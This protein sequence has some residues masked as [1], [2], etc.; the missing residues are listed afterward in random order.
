MRSHALERGFRRGRDLSPERRD[1]LEG[2]GLA[3]TANDETSR[4]S[5]TGRRRTAVLSRWIASLQLAAAKKHGF[6]PGSPELQNA[7]E[8]AVLETVS[9]FENMVHGFD[10]SAA[11]IAYYRG[12][13]LNDEEKKRAALRWLRGE[14]DTKTQ[15]REYLPV[16]SIIDDEN[17][18]DY[19]KLIGALVTAAG[20]K[21]LIVFIDEAVNL[22]KIIQ[23]ASRESNYEKLLTIFND[24]TQGK[25]SHIAFFFGG[26]P[27]FL[28]DT[29]RGLFSYEALRSRLSDNRFSAA[30]RLDYS[31]PVLRR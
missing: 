18:Y 2:Q 4:Q 22:Y 11:V 29:R 20:L 19:L 30:G 17:W 23:S 3:T 25:L 28:E 14:F 12:V 15:A 26:T 10:F 9:G 24:A 27:Q 5:S 16:S 8:T 13:A 31:A 7:V 21:G 1:R 6:A